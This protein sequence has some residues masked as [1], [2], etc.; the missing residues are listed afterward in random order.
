MTTPSPVEFLQSQKAV[1]DENIKAISERCVTLR[2]RREELLT[3][4]AALLNTHVT[5]DDFIECISGAI[6]KKK[7]YFADQ[8]ILS[9]AGP[10]YGH[11]SN[12]LENATYEKMTNEKI[13]SQ[14]G[15]VRL[16]SNRNN[17][18]EITMESWF[19]LLNDL[20][21]A[22]IGE[23]LKE[24]LMPGKRIKGMRENPFD[25]GKPMKEIEARLSEIDGE[26]DKID[27]EVDELIRSAG[28]FGAQI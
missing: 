19:Y 20:I 2:S 18:G 23:V 28:L 22:G 5:V 15:G 13:L 25:M 6:Q 4:K 27:E 11:K 10:D 7:E 21:I 9:L 16:L 8:L 1:I 14:L 26:V 17:P 3:E 24:H 12:F